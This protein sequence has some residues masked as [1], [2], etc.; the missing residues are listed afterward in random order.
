[1]SRVLISIGLICLLLGGIAW[2]MERAGLTLSGVG[3]GQ[4]AVNHRLKSMADWNMSVRTLAERPGSRL[5]PTYWNPATEFIRWNNCVP[6]LVASPVER[7]TPGRLPGDITIGSGGA[8]VYFPIT[9]C[10]LLSVVLSAIVYA[11]RA[12]HT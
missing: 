1:M 6:S 10:I 5:Q 8:R 2:I 7:P 3:N 11:M 9:T 12:L 4:A